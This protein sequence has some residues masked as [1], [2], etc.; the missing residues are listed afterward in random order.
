MNWCTH[1]SHTQP[2]CRDIHSVLPRHAAGDTQRDMLLE[3]SAWLQ[4]QA[5]ALSDL[6]MLLQGLKIDGAATAEWQEVLS[7]AQAMVKQHQSNL[8]HDTTSPIAPQA[9]EGTSDQQAQDQPITQAPLAE[10]PDG[11]QPAAEDTQSAMSSGAL[12][13]PDQGQEGDAVQ[14]PEAVWLSEMLA[15]CVS[16]LLTIHKYAEQPV[17]GQ[18]LDVA[19]ANSLRMLQPHAPSN[20]P[21]YRKIEQMISL[22]RN[23]LLQT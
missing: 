7:A 4:L 22:L 3:T 6:T 17:G 11:P 5:Q 16:M 14:K 23:R 1:N 9:L 13:K 18:R 10:A 21:V 19:L 20:Q 2:L 15:G 8:A 12:Q